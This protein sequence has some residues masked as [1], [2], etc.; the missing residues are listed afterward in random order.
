[1]HIVMVLDQYHN[2]NNGT[3]TSAHRF[4]EALEARGNT[5][6]VV[7]CGQGDGSQIPV[8]KLIIPLF[9]PLIEQ[10]G[11]SFAKPN[12]E[13]FYQAFQ[14]ADVVHFYQ[15]SP[16]CR[17]GE[18]IARQM[19]LPTM[20]SFHL[21]PENVTYSLGLGTSKFA[22]EALYR[23]FYYHFY[24]RFR[25]IH[26]PSRMIADQ[27]ESHH[28]NANIRVISNGVCDLFRPQKVSRP[29][30]FGNRFVILSIGRLSA[31][32]RQDL[33]IQA[34]QLSKH[35]DEIQLVFAGRGPLEKKYKKLAKRLP[36]PAIF[37]FYT[38]E[39]LKNLINACD[40]YV[41][42]SDAE[43]EGIS[44]MEAVACGVIPVISD[45]KLAATKSFALHPESIFHAGDAASLAEKIDFW[46]EHPELRMELSPAYAESADRM[47]VSLCA[48]EMERLYADAIAGYQ[49]DGYRQPDETRLRRLSHPEPEHALRAYAGKTWFDKVRFFFWTNALAPVLYFIDTVFLGLHIRGRQNLKSVK[50]GAIT[51]MNHVHD[52]DCTMVKLALFPRRVYYTSLQRNL[53]LPFVGWLIKGLGALSLP[54]DASGIAYF[55]RQIKRGIEDGD[56]VH[57]YPEAM[58]VKDH[59]D[60]RNFHS[61]A[62]F[63]A[64]YSGCP[65]VPLVL[66]RRKLK[67][68]NRIV[69]GRRRMQLSIGEPLY[70]DRSLP[71]KQAVADL[72]ERAI[73]SM[74]TMMNLPQEETMSVSMAFRAACI[75]LLAA[76][77]FRLLG[78]F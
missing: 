14:G 29:A 70:P 54:K 48:A 23:F 16:F 72:Q 24:T 51:V 65:V 43:I 60:L 31:E 45:S 49:K 30:E 64:V 8:K 59:P 52:M 55:E 10:Q 2:I 4:T 35:R 61:G 26:C 67:G 32:K 28:Y 22:N 6:T 19:K 42:A 41:H 66:T 7:A 63:T 77:V 11:F 68:L 18:K 46:I 33:L 21:Q 12:D 3:V 38:P 53:E 50:G 27:L 78:I 44:C 47:R 73:A 17:T 37:G 13:A 56:W 40:L 1:M 9:Q 20:A 36:N 69:G 58:L 74:K 62:F 57:Y 39:E 34:A 5:V 76:Q 25:Y 71:T 75:I 15:P